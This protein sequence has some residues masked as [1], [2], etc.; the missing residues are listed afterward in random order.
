M[1]KRRW[2]FALGTAV[3]ALTCLAGPAMAS[4]QLPPDVNAQ[5]AEIG[6]FIKDAFAAA[7]DMEIGLF[8]GTGVALEL[9][10]K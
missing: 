5:N 2:Q 4:C 7:A 8:E 3:Q 6:A 9:G 1:S 10:P